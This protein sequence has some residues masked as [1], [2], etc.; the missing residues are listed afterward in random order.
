M[1]VA[2]V[3]DQLQE[4]G[5]AERVLVSLKKIFPEADVYTSFYNP[6]M[7]G[8]HRENF[9]GWN[10]ITS[11]ADKIPFLKKLYSPLRFL[12]P[13]IWESMNLNKYDL[14]ISSSGSYMCKGVV[15]RPET[16]HISYLHHPPRYLYY[17]ETAVEWQKYWPI[18]VYGNLINHDLRQWDYLSS[19]RVDHFIANSEETRLRVQK[20]YRRD[21]EVIYPPVDI[22]DTQSIKNWKLEIGNYY[23]TVS[24]LA[25]A[26]H[27]NVLIEAANTYGFKLKVVG[28]GRDESYLKSIAG[29]TVEFVGSVTD[30]ELTDLYKN[31]KAFLFSSVD[32]EFGIAPIEA[33]G[34]LLPVIA[35]ASGGLKETVKEGENGYLFNKLDKESLIE[36]IKLLEKL[37]PE[38]YLQMRNSARNTSEKYSQENFKKNILNFVQSKTPPLASQGTPLTRGE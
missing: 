35:F 29:P 14:V 12:T 7:L 16:L 23:I 21:A 18:K 3:H 22:P 4:F 34:Y 37:A 24:R 31:A 5:G 19:Q 30:S 32:E 17:Y 11:W 20:F 6:E 36:K 2:I 15:T 26:K 13:L 27:V 1:K 38:K 28:T 10:I 33:M 25:R 9:N 8:I